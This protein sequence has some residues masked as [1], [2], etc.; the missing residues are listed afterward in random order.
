M[1]SFEFILWH[2]SHVE[3]C[4]TTE[5]TTTYSVLV[6]PHNYACEP[7]CS[8]YSLHL[9]LHPSISCNCLLHAKMSR[10][11]MH[12]AS[13]SNLMPFLRVLNVP[14]NLSAK[15]YDPN[16]QLTYT[17]LL[18]SRVHVHYYHKNI[19]HLATN[20]MFSQ[21]VVQLSITQLEFL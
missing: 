18:C 10:G 5:F 6:K 4:M 21:S 11:G 20:V 9:E 7:C 3:T 8:L 1:V 17:T 15:C 16:S 13:Q 19:Q 12:V 2:R 14:H